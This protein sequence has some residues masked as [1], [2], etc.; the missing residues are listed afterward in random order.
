MENQVK[1]LKAQK[2]SME[3]Q[4]EQCENIILTSEACKDICNYAIETEDPFVKPIDN[5][6]TKKLNS[7]SCTI[8]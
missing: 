2:R 5:P 1:M 8:L 3:K 4:L 6:F 7:T